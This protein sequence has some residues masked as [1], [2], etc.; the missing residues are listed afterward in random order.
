[1]LRLHGD[2]QALG[3]VPIDIQQLEPLLRL[4]FLL[5]QGVQCTQ[6]LAHRLD[7]VHE[8]QVDQPG[9]QALLVPFHGRIGKVMLFGCG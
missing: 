4:Q 5:V 3:R 7:H 6:H 1:M 2:K 9:T 8:R